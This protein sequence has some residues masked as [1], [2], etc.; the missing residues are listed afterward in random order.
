M[1][2][3]IV[4][5]DLVTAGIPMVRTEF[6]FLGADGPTPG[7][8]LIRGVESSAIP[9]PLDE[10]IQ[11]EMYE[12]NSHADSVFDD[13]G[14]LKFSWAVVPE[15]VEECL[16]LQRFCPNAYERC[17]DALD[18]PKKEEPKTY[19]LHVWHGEYNGAEA[20]ES[21][22]CLY[23][24]GELIPSDG[25]YDMLDLYGETF[26]QRFEK[27]AYGVPLDLNVLRRYLDPLFN[28]PITFC[29]MEEDQ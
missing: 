20:D 23:K 7:W 22:P 1:R 9:V 11:H 15:T 4:W 3:C 17:H 5:S 19:R 6:G 8:V 10:W 24:D 27:H 13:D 28:K 2:C 14:V 26:T 21:Q 12:G 25:M 29:F 18:V 16:H